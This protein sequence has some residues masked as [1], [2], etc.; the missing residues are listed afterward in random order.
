MKI[1]RLKIGNLR[2]EEWFQFFTEFKKL[3]EE[4]TPVSMGIEGQFHV[5]LGLYA[6]ADNV[7]EQIRK[8]DYTATIEQLDTQRDTIFSGFRDVVKGFQSHFDQTKQNAAN[9]L[10]LVFD[11]YGN[12]SRKGYSEETASIYNF[13]Q[14][15]NGQYANSVAALQLGDWVQKLNEVNIDFGK[16]VLERNIEQS[17]K[18]TRRMVEI[19]KEL[20]TCYLEMLVRIEAKILLQSDHNLTNF[21]NKINTNV[22]RYKNMLAQRNGRNTEKKEKKEKEATDNNE[23]KKK[24]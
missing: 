6:E 13:I 9:K 3:T 2:N 11:N 24:I 18:T 8:S 1:E 7:L 12:I 20:D 21:V 17:E 15:M 19:R 4:Q 14:D 10:M 5:F 16:N 22:I 23:F